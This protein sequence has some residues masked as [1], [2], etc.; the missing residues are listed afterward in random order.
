MISVSDRR[1]T[2]FRL[3]AQVLQIVVSFG[4][5]VACRRC[6]PRPAE[7]R[8]LANGIE[9]GAA[10]GV[11]SPQG[12][13]MTVCALAGCKCNPGV[14]VG[15]ISVTCMPGAASLC[16]QGSCWDIDRRGGVMPHRT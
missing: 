2:C 4:L 7:L 9:A 6:R 1:R 3:T 10:T 5:W 15:C 12:Y 16:T 13:A 8:A 11:T 14:V